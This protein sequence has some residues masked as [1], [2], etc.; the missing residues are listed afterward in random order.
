MKAL[1][2]GIGLVV[3]VSA[4]VA[5][6]PF[7]RLSQQADPHH[8][9]VHAGRLQRRGGARDRDRLAG[10]ASI[11]RRWSRTSR[12]AAAPSPISS[13]RSRRRTGTRMMIAPASFT[14]GPHL[15]RN[16]VY[17]PVTEFAPIILVADVPFVMV[18]PSSLPVH[19]LKEFID[20]AKK[21]PN[22]LTL[23]L[24]RR[25]HA[26]ASRRR[27]VQDEC[28]RRHD[29]RAVPRRDRRHSGSARRADRRVHRR[30]QFAP[31]AD[32]GGQAPR[33]RDGGEDPRAVV[34]GRADH[35]GI[36]LPRFRGRLR[37]RAGG[38]GRHAARG[39]RRSLNREI[40]KIIATPGFHQRMQTIGV[41]VVGST[42]AAYAK[43][44]RDDYDKWAKVVAA[45]GI[46]PQ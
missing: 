4:G 21:S 19:S 7:A 16:P 18:V 14:M 46:K 35:R 12:A 3:S 17:N 24:G 42:P 39:D 44:L 38:A 31:A 26:A 11:R 37:G 9:A 6:G 32:Q 25:R 8:R 23:R 30:D 27:T 13:W 5:D 2:I 43:F 10:T 34:A 22:K 33:H 1:V 29:P 45:A 28:R 15:S 41:D 40:G 20:L 36:G